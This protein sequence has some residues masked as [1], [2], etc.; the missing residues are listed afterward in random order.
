M[1]I[2]ASEQFEYPT[3]CMILS[4]FSAIKHRMK[5]QNERPIY[6][7]LNTH[8]DTVKIL[9][10]TEPVV[11]RIT[12]KYTT[13]LSSRV[14]SANIFSVFGNMIFYWWVRLAIHC[15]TDNWHLASNMNSSYPHWAAPTNADR[16]SDMVLI[17]TQWQQKIRD[18]NTV[19]LTSELEFRKNKA[20]FKN[21]TSLDLSLTNQKVL[22]TAFCLC[23]ISMHDN[24]SCLSM[25]CLLLRLTSRI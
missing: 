11:I 20:A 4:Y 14:Y 8:S 15:K 2:C 18:C 21:L 23:V 10:F 6:S 19:K 13:S 9:S 24:T 5:V 3:N 25:G 17:C 16:E 7:F 1:V 12:V 22:K